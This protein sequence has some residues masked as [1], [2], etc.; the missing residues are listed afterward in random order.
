LAG[1]DGAKAEAVPAD[2]IHSM[3]WVGKLG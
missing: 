2:E 3:D 1:G